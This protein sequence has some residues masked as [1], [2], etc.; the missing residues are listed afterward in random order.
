[1]PRHGKPLEFEILLADPLFERISQPIIQ[2]LERLGVKAQ[3]R[4]V[5][6]AQYQNRSEKYRFRHNRGELRAIGVARQRA[7]RILG[8]E[9]RGYEGGRNKIGIK[10]PVIDELI[11]LVM[12]RRPRKPDCAHPCP[13]PRS[14]LASFRHS[15]VAFA[16]GP[17]RLLGQ[18]LA[19]REEPKY[20]VGFNTWWIDNA[21]KASAPWPPASRERRS[22]D[23][24]AY[25]VRRILLI[26]PTLLEIM[27]LNFFII[28]AAPGGPVEQMIAKFRDGSA[29]TGTTRITG[30]FGDRASPAT[31]GRISSYR[32]RRG[33]DPQF[34]EQI[35]KMYGF[36][37]PAYERFLICCVPMLSSISATASSR[38]G[39]SSISFSRKCRCRFQSDCG[40]R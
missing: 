8:L 30:R 22:T 25:I 32:G 6:V 33:L 9:K 26:I 23:M 35:Q 31:G 37:K 36:D 34:I 13:G 11:E 4:T 12:P 21:E 3:V 16:R 15:P 27:I 28:Q 39:R 2:N 18:I 5:D 14:A 7:A 20:S 40:P 24:L 10:D 19:P 17:Y 38:A 29:T 1:M